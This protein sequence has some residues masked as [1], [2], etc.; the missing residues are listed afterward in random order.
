MPR[1]HTPRSASPRRPGRRQAPRILAALLLVLALAACGGGESGL[2]GDAGPEEVSGE[3]DW[4]RYDGETLRVVLNQHPWQEAVEPQLG[5]FEELTGIQVEVESLPEEQFRQRVQ[6][7]MTGKSED[8]DVFMTNVQN[9]GAKFARN[10]W[11]SDLS[12]FAEDESLVPPDYDYDDFSDGVLEG[13]TFDQTLGGIPIQLETQM[14]FYRKD[15]LEQAG[16]EV[17]TTLE[18]LEQVAEEIDEPGGTRAFVA[19]GD[20]AAAVTQFSTYLYNYGGTWTEEGADSAAFASKEGVEAL[21]YYARMIREYGPKGAVNMSWEEALPLFQQGQ[22][23]MYTDASTFL[24][25]VIDEGASKV[26]DTAGFAKMPSGPGGETQ[27]FNGWA[28]GISPFSQKPN[29]SWYFV[30]WATSPEVVEELTTKGI[31]GAR[32]SV[33]FGDDYPQDW[34]T[35]FTESLPEARAQLPAVGPVPEVRDAIG[36]AIV[37]AIQGEPVEPALQSSAEQFNQI[38]ETT[39]AGD[40]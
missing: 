15:I 7:E 10:G 37:E 13:H 21:G 22:V 20:A 34:V 5:E 2:A 11:Y 4:K 30:A 27:T 38:V 39:G 17:P 23:A 6:V 26:A 19:R 14:L 24:P 35:A 32:E 40:G 8:L 33:E 3:F 31:A 1:P 16:V 28:L 29:A 9:E 18:E 25:Q 12:Q 36:T